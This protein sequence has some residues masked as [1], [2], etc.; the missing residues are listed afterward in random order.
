M[1]EDYD[2]AVRYAD[3]VVEELE[4]GPRTLLSVDVED[5]YHEVPGG[6]ELY[7]RGDLPSNLPRNVDALL[8]LFAV[9]GAKATFFVLSD[10]VPRLGSQ[11]AR[12]VAEGHEVASHGHAHLRATWASREEFRE[13]VRR[14]KA[15]LEDATGREIKGFRA[16]YFAVTESNLWALD[17]IAEAGYLFDSSV[18]PVQNFAYGVPT[19][20][21]RPHRLRNGLV[22][23]PLTRV[24]VLGRSTMLAGGFY[25]R[26]YPLWL[27]LALLR[28]RDPTLPRVVY[29]HPYEL[30]EPRLNL[31]DLGAD[32]PGLRWRPR[33]IKF[34]TTFNRRATYG[35]LDRLLAHL[36]PG[37]AVG[38]VLPL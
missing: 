18:C 30:D 7:A 29:V 6:R 8:D 23:V 14:A 24:R 19:A 38:E 25:L 35:R 37:V 15:T 34:A 28:L 4:P 5:Y 33:T 27:T 1:R 17:E 16:P 20:P 9:R 10:T 22:E 12:I 32:L 11:L 26:L 13:D 21:E 2:L 36:G 31:W 3:L